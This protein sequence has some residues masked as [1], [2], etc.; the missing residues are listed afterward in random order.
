MAKKITVLANNDAKMATNI[1]KSVE[2]EELKIGDK[3]QFKY[4]N[5]QCIGKIRSIYN[6]GETINVSW[7]GKH[8]AF[9]YK[10]LKKVS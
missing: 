8:A 2:D 7:N 4:S 6:N 5:E 10:C 3:V 9:Y 1:T